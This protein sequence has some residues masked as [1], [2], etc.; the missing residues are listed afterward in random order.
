MAPR[1]HGDVDILLADP[2]LANKVLN[3]KAK[4]D[5][6]TMCQDLWRWVSS[7]PNGYSV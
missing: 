4:H 7:Y 1:R 3:W 6:N 5:L 2:A